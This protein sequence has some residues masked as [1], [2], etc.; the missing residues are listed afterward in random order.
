MREGERSDHAERPAG[1]GQGEKIAFHNSHVVWKRLA[2]TIAQSLGPHRVELDGDYLN[3]APRQGDSDCA[4]TGTELDDELARAKVRF[5]DDAVSDFGTKEI[6]TEPA[7]SLVA[8]CPPRGGHGRSP[9]WAWPY[10]IVADAWQQG[11]P[12]SHP[13]DPASTTDP[14]S[15]P[16]PPRKCRELDVLRLRDQDSVPHAIDLV[17]HFAAVDVPDLRYF[18]IGAD[19]SGLS[20]MPSQRTIGA[21]TVSTNNE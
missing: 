7:S 16:A 12:L 13:N 4:E 9:S 1:K 5:G 11:G 15:Q 17:D 2:G 10:F 3:L 21:R 6:L 20:Q 8:R 19:L 18:F 14:P